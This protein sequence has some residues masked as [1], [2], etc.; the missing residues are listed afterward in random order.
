MSAERFVGRNDAVRRIH[1]V[2]TGREAA[3]GNLTVLSIEGTGGIGKTYLFNHA[4]GCVD[5]T[6]R[7]YLVLRTDGGDPSARTLVRALARMVDGA[8]A[9]AIRGK[10]SGYYFPSVD[11]VGKTIDVIRNQAAAE[12]QQRHQNDEDGR[13]ALLRFLELAFET[14][15]RVNDAIPIT[16]KHVDFNKLDKAKPH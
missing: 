5:L 9:E 3:N 12:F 15:K 6:N 8:S 11:R 10:P 14:G 4:I 2:L 13:L 7:N 16:K 1:D